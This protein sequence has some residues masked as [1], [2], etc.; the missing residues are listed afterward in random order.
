MT[1]PH[2][3]A[4]DLPY[5]VSSYYYRV[6]FQQR[7]APHIHC[8]LWLKDSKGKSAPTFWSADENSTEHENNSKVEE[9]EKIA[10][11]IISA[12]EDSALC[13]KHHIEMKSKTRKNLKENESCVQC[14]SAS[15]NFV[16][17]EDHKLE[18]L[19]E[20]CEECLTLKQNVK[21]FQTHSHTFTCQKNNKIIVVDSNEGFGRYDGILRGPKIETVHCRFNFPQFPLNKTTFILG[22]SK[23]LEEGVLQQRR[24]DLQ[25]IK[26]FLIRKT[27]SETRTTESNVEFI[28]FENLTFLEFLLEVGM[29][30]EIKSIE[31]YTE[32]EKSKAHQRYIDAISASIRGSG[33]VF[34]KRG[35]KD[36]FT[37]NF[38]RKLMEVHKANHDLQIVVDQVKKNIN[39]Y[40][41]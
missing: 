31:S 41:N 19:S 17:C 5:S 25:R 40:V 27:F 22:M 35:T 37:N 39:N 12:S 1:Y 23:D 26:K 13:D 3:F 4:D 28:A 10:R 6:E 29:F 32:E 36:V 2:F 24:N 33:S 16:E 30:E 38:N 21:C 34:L 11:M 18:S 14:Y 8:L 20:E 9:I 15:A 7:G